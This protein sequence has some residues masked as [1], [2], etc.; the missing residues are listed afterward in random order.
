MTSSETVEKPK[1][2]KA[3]FETFGDVLATEKTFSTG[4]RGYYGSG[5]IEIAGK[6]YQVSLNIVEIGSKPQANK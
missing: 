5:K 6:R 3:T 4:S 1:S 2:V